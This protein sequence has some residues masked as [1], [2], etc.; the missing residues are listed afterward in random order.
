MHIT[1]TAIQII[2]S[3]MENIDTHPTQMDRMKNSILSFG[4]KVPS[5]IGEVD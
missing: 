5:N 1:N 2:K 3:E 4:P